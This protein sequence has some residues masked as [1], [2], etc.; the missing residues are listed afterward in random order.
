M[1][2]H[3]LLEEFFSSFLEGVKL[4]QFGGE[5]NCFSLEKQLM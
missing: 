4:L 5:L 2:K 1:K 3:Q